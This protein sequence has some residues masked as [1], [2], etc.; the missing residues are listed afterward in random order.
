MMGEKKGKTKQKASRF[1]R[2]IQRQLVFPHEGL[3]FDLKEIFDRINSEYFSSRMHGY[4]IIWG[5]KRKSPPKTTF[6]FASIQEE[7]RLIRVHPLLD[8][9]F[10]PVW[11]ME[12]VVYHEMLHAF[13]PEGRTRTGR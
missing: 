12:Y 7:D 13:V 1:G 11:F 10:V 4:R 2:L 9:S 3:H 8:A 6:V 5:R